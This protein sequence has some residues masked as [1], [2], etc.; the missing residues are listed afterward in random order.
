VDGSRQ[1]LANRF[2][3]VGPV[4]G[5]PG[6]GIKKSGLLLRKKK[7]QRR[8]QPR[9]TVTL[10]T[11]LKAAVRRSTCSRSLSVIPP[12]GDRAS[13]PISYSGESGRGRLW[14]DQESGLPLHEALRVFCAISAHF[15][16]TIC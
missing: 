16:K 12:P 6:R 11:A 2:A 1:G 15:S 3:I 5:V 8:R 14:I 13:N 4:S 7:P 9:S 10:P